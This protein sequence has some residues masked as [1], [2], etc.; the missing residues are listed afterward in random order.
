MVA[1]LPVIV[2]LVPWPS[3][4]PAG[5]PLWIEVVAAVTLLDIGITLVHFASHRVDWLWRFHAVHHSV[6]RMYG[7]NGLIEYTG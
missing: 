3:V 1:L 7:F 5:L 6:K 2:G 4:W